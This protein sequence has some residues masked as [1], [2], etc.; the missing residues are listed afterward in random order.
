MDST[1]D[2]LTLALLPGS[3]SRTACGLA[4]RGPVA[5]ALAHPEDH[6]DQLGERARSALRSGAARRAADAEQ[7]RCLRE[8]VV[9][10]GWDESLYPA[11]LRRVYDPPPVL[12]VKGRLEPPPAAP[13]VA[14]VGARQASRMGLEFARLLARDLAAAGA[15]IVSGL[16]R[17][18]D[19]SAHE[20]AL[21]AAGRTVAV[22]GSGLGCLYPP[23]N[24]ALAARIAE[25]GAV[26]S[27]F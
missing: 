22:L 19:T 8:G 15:T 24:A 5:D 13:A 7:A 14:V 23:E 27:E 3:R 16:A 20:G 6:P 2:L 10:V 18:V 21:A 11:L 17:G 26:V 4:A 1:F 25:S 12:W 9:L